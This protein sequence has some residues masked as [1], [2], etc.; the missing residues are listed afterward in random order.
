M[1][2]YL[3]HSHEISYFCILILFIC[4]GLLTTDLRLFQGL[5]PSL[6]ELLRVLVSLS[7]RVYSHS[8]LCKQY[9]P[10]MVNS[11][12][13]MYGFT[14]SVYMSLFFVVINTC[15]RFIHYFLSFPFILFLFFNVCDF[16]KMRVG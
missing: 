14:F 9:I 6:C 15:K 2:L 16:L 5:I 7:P 4:T 12:C 8:S 3:Y 1:V 11:V 10:C 13:L